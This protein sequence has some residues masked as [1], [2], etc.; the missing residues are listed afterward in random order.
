MLFPVDPDSRPELWVGFSEK[1]AEGKLSFLVRDGRVVLPDRRTL[2]H[3]GGADEIMCCFR[4]A[5]VV[6]FGASRG[7]A[8]GPFFAL[9]L[10]ADTACLAE[11]AVELGRCSDSVVR[12]DIQSLAINILY[13]CRS[14]KIIH[15][16]F[17]SSE[18]AL[19]GWV[20]VEDSGT[21]KL[22]RVNN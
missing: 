4:G 15:L 6:R 17:V 8:I 3:I 1:L 22:S 5:D 18:W 9:K 7:Q 16:P 19:D 10:S 11:Y 20:A 14:V 2:L 12:E 13:Q 21:T